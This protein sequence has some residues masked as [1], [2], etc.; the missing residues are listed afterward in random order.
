[1]QYHITQNSLKFIGSAFE[2]DTVGLSFPPG[3]EVEAP[4]LPANLEA[5]L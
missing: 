5:R 4:R 1:M 3:A 2:S